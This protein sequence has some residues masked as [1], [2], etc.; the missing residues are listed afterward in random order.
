MSGRSNVIVIAGN[1]IGEVRRNANFSFDVYFYPDMG[2]KE[3][4]LGQIGELI[5]QIDLIMRLYYGPSDVG[6]RL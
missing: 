3:L 6:P 2:G 1:E 4:T 5:T